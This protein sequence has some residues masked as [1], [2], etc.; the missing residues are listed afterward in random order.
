MPQPRT[1]IALES[2]LRNCRNVLTLGVKPNFEDYKPENSELIRRAPI[3]YY[4]S[5]FYADLFA[6]MGKKTFPGY[7]NY[8]CV[9]DKIK[10]TALFKLQ[11]ISHPETRIFYGRHRLSPW[12]GCFSGQK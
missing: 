1:V 3:I 9:Q 5:L 2:R 11:K 8:M 12:T 10:Q 6:S 4:P 7:H